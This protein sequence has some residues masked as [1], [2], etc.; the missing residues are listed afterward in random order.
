MNIHTSAEL[1]R[2]TIASN[3][4]AKAVGALLLELVI[5]ET[6]EKGYVNARDGTIWVSCIQ[7]LSEVFLSKAYCIVRIS[8]LCL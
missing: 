8:L 5:S 4:L 3:A 6:S 7:D 1:V 2:V